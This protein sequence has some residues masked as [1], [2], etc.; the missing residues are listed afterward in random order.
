M[1]TAA[2]FED[3]H[4]EAP[5]INEVVCGLSFD[6]VKELLAPYL[7]L[8][9]ERYK[10]AFSTCQELPP[11]PTVFETATGTGGEPEFQIL[12]LPPLPRIWFEETEGNG[13]IQ[14]Q[15]E[16]FHY[17]WRRKSDDDEYPHFESVFALFKEKL[18]AFRD[19]LRELRPEE[20]TPKQL[21]LTY[22]NHIDFSLGLDSVIDMG[23]VFSDFS[24]KRHEGRLEPESANWRLAFRFPNGQ[25]R[26]HV[27]VRSAMRISDSKPI[28]LFDLTARGIGDDRTQKG[29]DT[30]FRDA[31]DSIVRAFVELT[32]RD[33]Q[34]AVWRQ[35]K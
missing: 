13:L 23:K 28:I 34:E 32:T 25:G 7:G 21:E 9:W 4:F 1:T 27:N 18:D 26:L 33:M 35:K 19:F 3:L 12:D 30:W 16:R 17:N 22:V 5:P 2:A 15:R 24:W 20:L 6:P 11:L 14:V 29:I 8:L 10:P 31:H